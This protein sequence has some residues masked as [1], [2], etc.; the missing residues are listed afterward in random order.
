MRT[1]AGLAPLLRTGAAAIGVFLVLSTSPGGV[2]AAV[3]PLPRPAPQIGAA[4]APDQELKGLTSLGVVIEDLGAKAADCGL[5]QGPIEAAVSKSLADAGLRVRRNADEDTFVYVHVMTTIVGSGLCVS[6]YDTF[7]YSY[8]TTTL[9]YQAKPL[10][11]QVS[12]LHKGGIAGGPA[13]TL[14]DSIVKNIKEDVDGFAGRIRAA[15]R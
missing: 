8:A 2:W 1:N 11:L 7:L 9:S 13:A 4:P 3:A 15:N 10:L 6:R 14:G 5:A 12:L